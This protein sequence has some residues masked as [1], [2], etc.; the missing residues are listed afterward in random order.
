MTHTADEIRGMHRALHVACGLPA[1]SPGY[2]DLANWHAFLLVLAP[3]AEDTEEGRLTVP[4][5]Q[6]VVGEMKRQNKSGKAQWS[7]RPS[8]LLR[9]P[10]LFR[11][12]VLIAREARRR[13]APRPTFKPATQTIA[14]A[15]RA[16]EV[17]VEEEPIDCRQAF[18][19]LRKKLSGK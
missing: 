17:P 11:D 14:G 9:D 6:D 7:L 4:D 18:A 8:K 16:V 19:D 13:R 10:E 2:N 12:L 1:L 3:L 15:T 5:I